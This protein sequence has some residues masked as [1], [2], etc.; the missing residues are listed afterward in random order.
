[1]QFS[2]SLDRTPPPFYRHTH[3]ISHTEQ[4]DGQPC[5]GA[6]GRAESMSMC[7]RRVENISG[8]TPGYNQRSRRAAFGSKG[9]FCFRRLLLI[10]LL[11]LLLPVSSMAENLTCSRMPMLMERFL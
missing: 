6:A 7:D 2:F 11:I 3:V 4:K 5:P 10:L 8:N 1:M 9:G